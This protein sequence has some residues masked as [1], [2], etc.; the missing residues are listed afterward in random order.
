MI[1]D[2]YEDAAAIGRLFILP[3]GLLRLS[4][5]RKKSMHIS[6]KGDCLGKNFMSNI[7]YIHSFI[8]TGIYDIVII[9]Q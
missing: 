7:S 6:F 4:K 8:S 3:G 9:I 1:V 2:G 5:Q